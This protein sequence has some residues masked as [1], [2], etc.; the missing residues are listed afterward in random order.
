MPG[1]PGGRRQGRPE[2]TQAG[3]SVP[4]PHLRAAG[5]L[6]GE[7]GARALKAG[8]GRGCP[9]G[10]TCWRPRARAAS[11]GQSTN[12]AGGAGGG[13]TRHNG[14]WAEGAGPLL[15]PQPGRRP[16]LEARPPFPLSAAQGGG[17]R[18]RVVARRLLE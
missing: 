10:R 1:S 15:P 7:G 12:A 8:M 2:E 11:K 3:W 13:R 4:P 14:P 18:R 5:T 6:R 9:A 17:G 16:P